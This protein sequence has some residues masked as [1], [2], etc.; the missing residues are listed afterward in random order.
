MPIFSYTLS[1]QEQMVGSLRRMTGQTDRTASALLR[2]KDQAEAVCLGF[3]KFA[4]SLVNDQQTINPAGQSRENRPGI[5]PLWNSEDIP[6]RPVPVTP[7]NGQGLSTGHPAVASPFDGRTITDALKQGLNSAMRF[8]ADMLKVN[9]VV[10]LDDKS[11]NELGTK[12]RKIS[13]DNRFDLRVSTDSFEKIV[14]LMGDVDKALEILDASIKG[15]ESQFADLDTVAVSLVRTLRALGREEVSAS[16]AMD[17]L[18][19]AKRIG[20]GDFE[21]MSQAM[22]GLV[23]D[24]SKSGFSFPEAA[25][26]YAAATAK[27]I[28]PTTAAEGLSSLF[29]SLA[30]PEVQA[31]LTDVGIAVRTDNGELKESAA[32]L[33]EIQKSMSNLDAQ[34]RI[35]LL[36][37]VRIVDP[38]AQKVLSSL[39]SDLS[40]VNKCLREVADSAGETEKAVARS[41]HTLKTVDKMWNTLQGSLTELGTAVLPVVDAGLTALNGT[42]EAM[43]WV[44][45]KVA[46]VCGSWLDALKAGNPYVWGLTAAVGA[47][48]TIYGIH[49]AVL[50]AHAIK[51]GAVN[52]WNKVTAISTG[53]LQKAMLLLKTAFV[54][55]PW[56]WVAL[57]IGAVAGAV[58]ALSGKT[59]EAT[60]EFAAFNAELRQNQIETQSSF[61]AAALATE[62]SEQRAAAI[63]KI[64]DKYGDYLPFLLSEKSTN[65]DLKIALEG[66]NA[67]LE[68]KLKLKYRDQELEG[69]YKQLDQATKALHDKILSYVP[70]EDVNKQ[71]EVSRAINAAT[72]DLQ[73]GTR[74]VG[75]VSRE[76][77]QRFGISNRKSYVQANGVAGVQSQSEYDYI[78]QAFA[79]FHEK[80]TQVLKSMEL[81]RARYEVETREDSTTD[82]SGNTAAVFPDGASQPESPAGETT[83][84]SFVPPY[85]EPQGIYA[86]SVDYGEIDPGRGNSSR[87]NANQLSAMAAIASLAIPVSV[88]ASDLTAEQSTGSDRPHTEQVSRAP[89]LQLQKFCDHIEIHIDKADGKGHEQIEREIEQVLNETL[90][91]YFDDNEV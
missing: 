80:N 62:G 25:G 48:T 68:Q 3:R 16:G 5:T 7:E 64:N 87:S 43:A 31:R 35:K 76:M 12:I 55:T 66:V 57:G 63:Q 70:K 4:G 69:S 18:I 28:D 27:G 85:G 23:S 84:R 46:E 88:A 52:A 1:Q 34:S 86:H 8:E 74:T 73:N 14:R 60:G 10:G 26:M 15:A 45:T 11:L 20:A 33:K 72:I 67:Q 82:F 32:M 54:T 90:R 65:E 75:D 61:D 9:T 19:A 40:K 49:N 78:A 47:A 41:T 29:S 91:K 44:I 6:S 17:T 30:D 56:G 77:E 59:S 38:K 22:P 79:A 53:V 13:A 50:H 36:D 51:L 37:S 42:V 83:L 2:L 39:I 81:T 24:A 89:S 71:I 21:V 58:A